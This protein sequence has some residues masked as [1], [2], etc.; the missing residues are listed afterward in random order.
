ML[1]WLLVAVLV[2]LLAYVKQRYFT[3]RHGLPGLSPHFYVGNLVQSGILFRGK[4]LSH[5]LV[6]FQ[7]KF[8]DNF[9]F[10][11]GPSRFMVIGDIADVQHIFNHRH[12]YDQG[13]V[14]IEKI[15]LLFPDGLGCIKGENHRH[16]LRLTGSL[17]GAQFRRHI[18]IT[19]P[20]FRRANIIGNLDLIFDCTDQLLEQWRRQP[21]GHVH[22]DIVHQS[23]NLLLAIFGF[24][25]FDCDL[26]LFDRAPDPIDHR[27]TEALQN[28]LSTYSI[29]IYSPRLLSLIYLTLSRRYRRSRTCIRAYF[30]TMI[31]R[32]LN[33]SAASRAQR[34]R[35]CLI[36]SLVASMQH[37]EQAEASKPEETKRGLSQE[38]ILNEMLLFLVA[39]FES[40]SSVLAWFIHLMSKHPRVQQKIK[41]ELNQRQCL[42]I[43]QL[44]SMTYLNC[45]V[46][47]VLRF[48]PPASGTARTLTADDRLPHSG[49]ELY[50]GESVFIP[51]YTLSHDPRH[52][53]I[54]P[55]SFCPE[56]FLTDDEHHAPL[57]LI[58]FGG[59]HRQCIARD[60]ALFELK[61][62]AARLMQCVT[63]G[64]AGEQSNAGGHLPRITVMPK[65]VGVTLQFD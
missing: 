25:A 18:S 22:T 17:S 49:T 1:V 27:L 54:D 46:K 43:E 63:F 65:H 62:I 38:E 13:D 19:A 33:D 24:M 59:G 42:T 57:A 9:Q 26:H 64:D 35:T 32:E 6:E 60:L 48:C 44:D 3:L 10:W 4:S 31:D 40:T 8:G 20:I 41:A 58:P 28:L 51:F 11:L 53:S 15:S 30:R 14:F 12:I 50:R 52:W 21:V 55:H 34:K 37:D 56:R 23:K 39:G 47:E 36:A 7:K 29:V 5:V 2:L 61:V 45:V 16:I